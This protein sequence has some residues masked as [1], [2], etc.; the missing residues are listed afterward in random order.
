MKEYVSN[1]IDTDIAEIEANETG[2][3]H[4]RVRKCVDAET[5]AVS[6]DIR[7]FYANKETGTYTPT[8]KGIRLS[9][10]VAK[11]VIE[12]LRNDLDQQ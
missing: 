11:A 9:T 6:Y 7:N 1:T 10:E 5:G 4:V 8:Q 12:A 2:S 3:R